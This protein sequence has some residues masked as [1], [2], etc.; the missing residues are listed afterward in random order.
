VS[1]RHEQD[2]IKYKPRYRSQHKLRLLTA[3][4][5]K[6][7]NKERSIL[8]ALKE[9]D[10][11]SWLKDLSPVDVDSAGSV[12]LFNQTIAHFNQLPQTGLGAAKMLE[13][14]TF[15]LRNLGCRAS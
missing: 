14:L 10:W 4:V 11:Q 5:G 15:A 9:S 8:N 6:S 1:Q 12:R 13:E 7:R 3:R 2:P